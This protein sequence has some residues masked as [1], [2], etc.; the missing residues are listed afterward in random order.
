MAARFQ[1]ARDLELY[2]T[3]VMDETSSYESEEDD[4]LLLYDAAMREGQGEH[5]RRGR[6]KLDLNELSLSRSDELFRFTPTDIP[7]LA[8]ASDLPLTM[9]ALNRSRW[10]RVEGFA[11]L[12]RRFAYPNRLSDSADDVGRGEAEIS[13]IVNHTADFLAHRWGHLFLQIDQPWLTHD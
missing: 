8:A 11:V 7:R 12:L 6:P 1:D 13:L 5:G 2:M 10:G 3:C 9:I 4:L